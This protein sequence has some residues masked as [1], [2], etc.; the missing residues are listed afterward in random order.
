MPNGL[1]RLNTQAKL[2]FVY[3]LRSSARSAIGLGQ[4]SATLTQAFDSS[5]SFSHSFSSISNASRAANGHRFNRN[6]SEPHSSDSTSMLSAAPAS[7][8]SSSP[9]SEDVQ[10][11]SHSSLSPSRSASHHAESSSSSINS[12]EGLPNAIN[13]RLRLARASD[14]NSIQKCNLAT[15][16]ENYQAAFYASHLKS[17][18]SLALVAERIYDPSAPQP[19]SGQA[20]D[21]VG[22]VLGKVDPPIASQTGTGNLGDMFFT[23][24]D[25]KSGHVTSLAVLKEYRRMGLAS[26][27]MDQLHHQMLLSSVSSVGLHVRVSNKAATRLYET[28]MGYHVSQVISGYYQDGEDAYLMT[29][30]LPLASSSGQPH[31]AD[32]TDG[33]SRIS[34]RGRN[35]AKASKQLMRQINTDTHKEM[36]LPRM[37]EVKAEEDEPTAATVL[38]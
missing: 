10:S 3:F 21:V 22:Y 5:Q 19:S 28:T 18:P 8:G 12:Q 17:W 6:S 2:L 9:H 30:S 7:A 11:Q 36:N 29:L 37:M 20:P 31:K 14:I 1:M 13:L 24:R 32:G 38:G 34:L 16:P 4:Q 35:V 23:R 25:K 26:Q 15:L 27:L 33:S